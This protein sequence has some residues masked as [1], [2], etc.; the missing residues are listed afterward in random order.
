MIATT[1]IS[2]IKVKPF[3]FMGASGISGYC[4]RN[5]RQGEGVTSN[6]ESRLISIQTLSLK[7]SHRGVWVGGQA[8]INTAELNSYSE[9]MYGGLKGLVTRK[10]RR[11]YI[12][13]RLG[14]P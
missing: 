7:Y 1:I 10:V 14:V 12:L 2:S 6:G 13:R 8:T 5:V 9:E 3:C 4:R 11:Y